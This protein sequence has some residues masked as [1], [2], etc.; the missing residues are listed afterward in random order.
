MK[1]IATESTMSDTDKLNAIKALERIPLP[2]SATSTSSDL[3]VGQGIDQQGQPEI[4]EPDVL[5]AFGLDD[6][7]L[8][9]EEPPS[10]PNKMAHA[11]D[12]P[13]L[14]PADNTNG[15]FTN[16]DNQGIPQVGIDDD[17]GIVDYPQVSEDEYNKRNSADF[18]D[19]GTGDDRI[20]D[21]SDG[22]FKDPYDLEGE[23]PPEDEESS[24]KDNHIGPNDGTLVKGD[25]QMSGASEPIPDNSKDQIIGSPDNDEQP[26]VPDEGFDEDREKKNKI[27]EEEEKDE[28]AEE[29][30]PDHERQ[31]E[32]DD[33]K[34]KIE[35]EDPLTS[36]TSE[37]PNPE[38]EERKTFPRL[39]DHPLTEEPK[40]FNKTN[41]ENPIE[42]GTKDSADADRPDVITPDTSDMLG[43]SGQVRLQME[44]EGEDQ[45]PD[46]LESTNGVF[47]NSGLNMEPDPMRGQYQSITEDEYNQKLKEQEP[48]EDGAIIKPEDVRQVEPTGIKD[49][50]QVIAD[51]S[52][53][54]VNDPTDSGIDEE[55]VDPNILHQNPE[56]GR[57]YTDL[58]DEQGNEVPDLRFDQ[59]PDSDEKQPE[60]ELEYEIVTKEEYD[61]HV[62]GQMSED[63]FNA[64]LDNPTMDK[65]ETEP[66]E[67]QPQEN[68]LDPVEQNEDGEEQKLTD[69]DG[70]PIENDTDSQD[71]T[72]EETDK[73]EG[74]PE[75]PKEDSPKEE[76]PEKEEEKP[77]KSSKKSKPKKKEDQKPKDQE[78]SKD[79]VDKEPTEDSDDGDNINDSKVEQILDKKEELESE[80]LEDEEIIDMLKDEFDLDEVEEDI[81]DESGGDKDNK[82]E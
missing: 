34:D 28:E 62:D 46:R 81:K 56:N 31:F 43:D 65:L 12:K 50:E 77:K 11:G 67:F 51:Q 55:Q 73:S 26:I 36:G 5:K 29:A 6:D 60:V 15:R 35:G 13:V 82:D 42:L 47:D 68:P 61:Q 70:N 78:D 75:S 64:E 33:K 71:T 19:G 4:T 37:D 76:K 39:D 54:T 72:P 49:P 25:M 3:Y 27:V 44:E 63:Q 52:T 24:I 48:V 74:Q 17:E 16:Q 79:Q 14:D 7:K 66:E 32:F 57:M 69:V 1:E 23:L 18:T 45:N 40:D 41:E 80:G 2:P 22:D 20:N 9:E 21:E 8:K 38:Q 10:S 30:I 58:T 53:D 59:T